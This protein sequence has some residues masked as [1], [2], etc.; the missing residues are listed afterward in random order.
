MPLL[1]LTQWKKVQQLKISN[2]AIG[3]PSG[4]SDFYD[5]NLVNFC[6]LI[7]IYLLA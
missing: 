6:K 1:L 2:T 5:L 3:G 7:L 4:D